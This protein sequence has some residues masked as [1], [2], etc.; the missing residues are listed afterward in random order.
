MKQ[1]FWKP[2]KDRLQSE[3]IK[4]GHCVGCA[5]SLAEGERVPYPNSEKL[6]FVTCSCRR[7]YVYD[8]QINSYRRARFNEMPLLSQASKAQ[9]HHPTTDP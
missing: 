7:V 9:S 3:L 4:R 8:K 5:K 2:I 6:E 1:R